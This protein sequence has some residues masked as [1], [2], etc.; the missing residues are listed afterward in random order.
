MSVLRCG[1]GRPGPHLHFAVIEVRGAGL[2]LNVLTTFTKVTV[3]RLDTGGL[4]PGVG[5]GPGPWNVLRGV[6]SG[7][8]TL[9]WEPPFRAPVVAATPQML[10]GERLAP[11]PPPSC[12]RLGELWRAVD[13]KLVTVVAI[14]EPA[15]T[16]VQADQGQ[17]G[18]LNPW[19]TE[20][21]RRPGSVAR[22]TTL[23]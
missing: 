21:L 15:A 17:V 1:V 16:Q 18:D 10:L 20:Q 2:T 11:C 5:T 7:V 23:P 3:G 6:L 13:A 19:Q 22:L 4:V 14:K 9:L 12:R 8:T